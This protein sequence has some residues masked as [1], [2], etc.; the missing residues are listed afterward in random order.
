MANFD[1]IKLEKFL[2][3]APLWVNAVI[4]LALSAVV[5]ALILLLAYLFPTLIHNPS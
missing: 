4:W 3:E 2:R 5:V 1:L